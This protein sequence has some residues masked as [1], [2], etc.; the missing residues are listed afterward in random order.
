MS[1]RQARQAGDSMEAALADSQHDLLRAFRVRVRQAKP[2]L[3]QLCAC[4]WRP[5]ASMN[6]A[7]RAA[8]L[9]SG[10]QQA[11]PGAE[12]QIEKFPLW[13]HQLSPE[14]FWPIRYVPGA[15]VPVCTVQYL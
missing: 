5:I 13:Q 9:N 6:V 7:G 11:A 14:L 1:G 4:C 10:P 8:W 12:Q 2:A 15:V 3:L